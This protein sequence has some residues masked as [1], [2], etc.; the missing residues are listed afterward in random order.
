GRARGVDGI[1]RSLEHVLE[2]GGDRDGHHPAGEDAE[3]LHGEDGGDERAAGLLIGVLRHDG[4]GAGVVAADAKAE[5]EAEEA[6]GGHYALGGVAEGETRGDGAEDHEH[7]GHAIGALAAQLVA[8]PAK[9]ELTGEG[10]DE[11]DAIDAEETW[12]GR[13]P[14]VGEPSTWVLVLV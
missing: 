13:V 14:G 7:E 12:G 4:G 2:R 11:G 6:E 3:A 9:E 8:Q 1:G 10:A 5:P